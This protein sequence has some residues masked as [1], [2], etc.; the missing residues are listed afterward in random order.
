MYIQYSV[1]YIHTRWGSTEVPLPVSFRRQQLKTVRAASIEFDP[2]EEEEQE[3]SGKG[4][5]H[6]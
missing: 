3:K 2:S 5:V 6:I 1:L 4:A